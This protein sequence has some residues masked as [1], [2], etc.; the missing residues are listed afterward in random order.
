VSEGGL[1]IPFVVFVLSTY[2]YITPC[3]TASTLI[4]PVLDLDILFPSPHFKDR[5]SSQAMDSF[6]FTLS[7]SALVSAS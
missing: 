4:I 3:L 5:G 7:L 6:A 1:P 2:L